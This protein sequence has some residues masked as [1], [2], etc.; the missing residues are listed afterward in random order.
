MLQHT[1]S[2]VRRFFVIYLNSLIVT[3]WDYQ[4]ICIDILCRVLLLYHVT[5]LKPM[6]HF[7]TP[8]KTSETKDFL[9]FLGGYRNRTLSWNGLIVTEIGGK[10]FLYLTQFLKHGVVMVVSKYNMGCSGVW[11]IKKEMCWFS[12]KYATR[13]PRISMIKTLDLES[14]Y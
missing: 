11:D 8:L 13:I 1:I 12:S 14:P 10:L 9:T 5:H 7:Y 3:E 6:F 2:S 4:D